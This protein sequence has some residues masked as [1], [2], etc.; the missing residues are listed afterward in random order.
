MNYSQAI[1]YINS[2][3]VFG[4]KLGLSRIENLMHRLG[5]PQKQLSFIHTAGTNG[6]GSVCSYIAHILS[7]A[8][9]KTGL[10]VSPYVFDYTERFQVN[11]APVD[12][13]VFISAVSR[14]KA[15]VDGMDPA[16]MP[17]EFEV[18]TAV[19]FLIFAACKC[20]VVVLE[21]G[22]GG[23]YDSTNV[24]D[25]PLCSVIT[26]ISLDHTAVLGDTVEL[27]AEQ[28]AGIMKP[29]GTT[30]MYPVQPSGA[31]AVIRETARQTGNRLI[32]PDRSALRVIHESPFSVSAEY[33]GIRFETGI[34]GRAQVYNAVTAIEAVRAAFPAVG[35]DSIVSGIAKAHMPARCQTVEK[36]RPV[37]LDG[38]HNPDGVCS[39][40]SLLSHYSD[41]P[42]TAVIGMMRDKDVDSVL[43]KLCP[44]FDR[45]ITV[46]VDNP[47]ACSADELCAVAAAYC[48]NVAAAESVASAVEDAFGE[49][50]GIVVC[51]SFYLMSQA[52][53]ALKKHLPDGGFGN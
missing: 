47:R 41:R 43:K 2:F 12:K 29:N 16:L 17:T 8:G 31:A 3:L 5:D 23:L 42:L 9:M 30:V 51:G 40:I 28:K 45:V 27:I 22:L 50:G 32:V 1:D 46:T 44:L 15:A 52:Y 35:E 21:V 19:G 20:D 4:S 36:T 53:P 38:A 18:V 14:V 49:E 37:I 7:E 34:A 33:G 13:D 39:L 26:S 48:R 24:I 6:K 10:F 25:T 11:N